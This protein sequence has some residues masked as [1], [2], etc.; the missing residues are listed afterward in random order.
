MSAS[1]PTCDWCYGT[2]SDS[3]GWNSCSECDGTGKAVEFGPP[4]LL[5]RALVAVIGSAVRFL[6]WVLK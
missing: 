4:T 6:A 3:S 2:G 1:E 5:E